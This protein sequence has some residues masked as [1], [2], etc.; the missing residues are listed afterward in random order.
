MA[1]STESPAQ[2]P[3]IPGPMGPG[4]RLRRLWHTKES[5][6]GYVLLSPTLLFVVAMLLV[7]MV[8]LVVQSF[9]GGVG[10]DS[11]IQYTLSNYTVFLEPRGEIY[12]VLLARSLW[13][14]FIMTVSV[15]LFCYPIA[16][17]L[18]MHVRKHKIFW[19]IIITILFWTS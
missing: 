5:L 8:T 13:M 14:S 12:R 9:W 1:S 19:L 3:A 18:A 7:S 17:V 4:M 6:R 16:Y 15:I 2:R 10:P 11:K